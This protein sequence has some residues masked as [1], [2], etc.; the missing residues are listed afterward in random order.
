MNTVE[1]W[2]LF[3]VS[4]KGPSAGNPFTEQSVS[5]TFRSKNEIV[6]VDGFYDGDGVYKVRFMP[7]FTGDYVYETV[8][9]FPE[10]ESAGDFTVTEPTGNNHGPVRIANTYHF[11]YEDTTPYYS[12]GTTC[13]AWAH[14]P[15]EVH[16]QTLEE[17]DKG[18]FNK[19]RFCVFPKHYIHNFR[20][21]ETFPYEGTPV[22]NSNLTEENFSYFV[23]FSGNNWDFTRFNPE[24]FRRMERCIVELQERG[25]EADIIVMHPY[26]RWGFSVMNREQDDLYWN[27]VIARF[28]A[29]R[30]VWWSL[31]NE[32]DL[33][34]AKKLE[35]WEHYADLLCKK[36]RTTTCVPST[37]A[38]RSTT[39][40]VRGLR[41]AACSARIST[42]TW[43]TPPITARATKSLS[44]G[45]RLP[46]KA[47]LI[48]AGA[49]SPGR[50]LPAASGKLPCAAA[51]QATARPS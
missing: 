41:I 6:T 50:S 13:Y 45:M 44:C 19:M 42:V 27:Y 36:I 11:A 34:R 15:E 35:D 10:A 46:T 33:M 40:L 25:I 5:A 17:L 30:N 43:N 8:G 24:H 26:D 22:D 2:G 9:S 32:Y 14:Q 38:Y 21:P 49:I 7:S 23:D 20:D 37:T 39:T 29:Y 28:S 12:V 18:Y 51:T 47:I 16:K 31:A 1:K 4:L 48:W 3:E